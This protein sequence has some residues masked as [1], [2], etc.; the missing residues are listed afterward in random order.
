MIVSAQCVNQCQ[1]I[2]SQILKLCSSGLPGPSHRVKKQLTALPNPFSAHISFL[3]MGHKFWWTSESA[4]GKVWAVI[5]IVESSDAAV[6]LTDNEKD[7]DQ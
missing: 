6:A 2:I 3:K 7:G 5:D 1:P 4:G